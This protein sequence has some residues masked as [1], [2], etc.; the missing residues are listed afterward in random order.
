MSALPKT[1]IPNPNPK[2]VIN[3]PATI[4]RL[5][6]LNPRGRAYK[7]LYEEAS[8]AADDWVTCACGALC[9]AIPREPKSNGP[10]DQLLNML[11]IRFALQIDAEEYDLALKTL[12]EIE[13]RST[14]LLKEILK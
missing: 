3:W 2:E 10:E 5:M 4:K 7:K 1:K 12:D 14:K 8:D 13:A 9:D 6:T 11:G